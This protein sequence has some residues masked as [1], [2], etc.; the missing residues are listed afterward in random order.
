MKAATED[1]VDFIDRISRLSEDWRYSHE[2]IGLLVRERWPRVYK[3][4]RAF[5]LTDR[6][7]ESDAKP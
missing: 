1:L 7:V 2:F 3:R 4:D 6:E 5:K